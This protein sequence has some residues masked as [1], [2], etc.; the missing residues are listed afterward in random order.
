[1]ELEAMM[2]GMETAA[3]EGSGDPKTD[4]LD[5]LARKGI[6]PDQ[7]MQ[8]L[9]ALLAEGAINEQEYQLLKGEGA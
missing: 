4:V 5:R 8:N 6:Q 7:V 2:G 9:D 1:M 3:A